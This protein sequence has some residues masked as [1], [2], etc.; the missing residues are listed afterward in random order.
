MTD[1][2][3]ISIDV[4]GRKYKLFVDRDLEETYRKAAKLIRDQIVYYENRQ[5]VQQDDALAMA[6]FRIALVYVAAQSENSRTSI[7][8]TELCK[9]IEDVLHND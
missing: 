1:K 5:D 4:A 2:I 3:K 9:E 6:A 8:I 7:A